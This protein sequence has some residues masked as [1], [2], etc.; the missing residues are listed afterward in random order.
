MSRVNSA[1]CAIKAEQADLIII[2]MAS[3][4]FPFRDSIDNA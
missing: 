2:S 3:D 1:K 4:A